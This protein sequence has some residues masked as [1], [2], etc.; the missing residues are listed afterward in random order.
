MFTWRI[1]YLGRHEEKI[2][3][4]EHFGVRSKWRVCKRWYVNWRPK[5]NIANVVI[6]TPNHLQS[7]MES[8]SFATD[9]RCENSGLCDAEMARIFYGDELIPL[10]RWKRCNNWI[11]DWFPEIYVNF[12]RMIGYTVC[13]LRVAE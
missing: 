1:Y 3:L 11:S 13:Q 8:N 9:K 4:F 12:P 7:W 6:R 2:L 10:L 5:S